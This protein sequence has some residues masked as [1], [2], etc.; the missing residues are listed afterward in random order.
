MLQNVGL[1][2]SGFWLALTAAGFSSLNG[3]LTT[4][5]AQS[6]ERTEFNS[7]FENDEED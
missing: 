6:T 4:V 2:R 5:L 7:T 1:M 3:T